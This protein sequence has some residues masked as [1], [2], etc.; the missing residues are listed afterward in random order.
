MERT[1][2]FHYILLHRRRKT[3]MNKHFL[4]AKKVGNPFHSQ[5]VTEDQ[6]AKRKLIGCCFIHLAFFYRCGGGEES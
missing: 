5:K 6:K 2:E 1:H 3:E 4:P